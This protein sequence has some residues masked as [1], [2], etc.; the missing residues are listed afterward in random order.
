MKLILLGPPGA[1]KGTQSLK[2]ME[3]LKIPQISTGDLLRESVRNKTELGIKAKEFIDSGKLVPDEL[4]ISIIKERLKREDC[5]KGFILDGFPRTLE[6]AEALEKIIAIDKVIELDVEFSALVKRLTGR[7]S[8][9]KDG[10]VY[11]LEFKPPKNDEKCDICQSPLIQ[12]SDDNEATVK[13]RIQ[14]YK[15]KTEP[16]INF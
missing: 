15:E 12:R 9:P 4:V 7:R 2:I 14:T 13:S 11:H 16:L 1:G 5:K 6:Q 3:K 8:C 10:S